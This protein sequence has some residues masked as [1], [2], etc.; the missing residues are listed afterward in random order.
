MQQKISQYYS[1]A[2]PGLVYGNLVSAISGFLIASK[3]QINFQLMFTM[4]L[5]ISLIMASGCVLNCYLDRDIDA[6]MKRTQKRAMV[7]KSVSEC[8]ALIYAFI[9]SLIGF[10]FLAIF[11][12]LLVLLIALTGF[13][14][15]VVAYTIFLKRKSIHSTLIG[16]I[17]GASP[18]LV[19]Y[20][21]I[22]GQFDTLA[23]ILFIILAIWQMPHSYALY[24]G[25]LE[26]YTKANISTLP[27]KRGIFRTKLNILLYVISFFIATY[28]LFLYK[29]V[30]V[31]Y[32]Y[33]MTAISI[34][35]IIIAIRGFY[36]TNTKLWAK[37]IFF[38]SIFVMIAFSLLISFDWV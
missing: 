10:S 13:F 14:V 37:K 1:L 25:Y 35:W 11:T 18:I 36:T 20:T 3:G 12:N 23:V 9:L 8:G 6:L 29:Y 19:G 4:L 27:V 32:L 28:L 34:F 16:S 30:G 5:G 7:T 24:I 15:Y 17:A 33:T 2:K 38:Y 31:F 21:S 22:T 26:D